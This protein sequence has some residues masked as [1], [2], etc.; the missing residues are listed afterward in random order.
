VKAKEISLVE[1]KSERCV[2]LIPES[3]R[4]LINL[5]RLEIMLVL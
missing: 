5:A 4:G 1:A 3:N 2:R